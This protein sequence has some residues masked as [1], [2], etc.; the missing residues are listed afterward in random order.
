MRAALVAS[1]AND[2]S[3]DG[4]PKGSIVVCG[5]CWRPVYALERGL[6]PGDKAGRSASAFRP[7]TVSDI[8]QLSDRPDLD[9]GWQGLLLAF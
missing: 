9:S 1:L 6:A 4:Y 7:L 5:D 8:V 2:P 3:F